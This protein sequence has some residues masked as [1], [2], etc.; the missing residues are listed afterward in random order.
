MQLYFNETKRVMLFE[1]LELTEIV[2]FSET[3]CPTAPSP[4][5]NGLFECA[6]LTYAYNSICY[7]KCDT[8]F[9]LQQ[10]P[11]YARCKADLTW[12]IF[13]TPKCKGTGQC[14]LTLDHKIT[15]HLNDL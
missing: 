7:A 8:G 14:A 4:P 11:S 10:Q 5:T 9:T 2:F 12:E 15:L 13:N 1:Y 6:D 3:L